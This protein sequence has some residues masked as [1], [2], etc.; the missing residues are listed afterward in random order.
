[1]GPKQ[2]SDRRQS[3]VAAAFSVLMEKGYSGAST[4][5]IAR[6]ARVSKR[7]LYTE[8]GSK[9]GILEALIAATSARMQVPLTTAEIGDRDTFRAALA[10]YGEAAL[11]ELTS[12]HVIAI[13]RLAAAEAGRSPELSRILDANG[14]E[15]N[16]RALVAL[17]AKGQQAGVLGPGDPDAMVGEFFSLLTGDVLMRLLLGAIKR[18]PARELQRRAENA[19]DAILRLHA[20]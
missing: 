8:F 10:R 14:R 9:A 16:R 13:N 15:S 4:L 17:M 6:R 7:D 1:M 20:A 19:T 12:P 11:T 5:E 2:D 3:I 18:P